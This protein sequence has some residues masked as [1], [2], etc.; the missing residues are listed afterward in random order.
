MKSQTS[1]I[2]VFLALAGLLMNS[3]AQAQ[4]REKKAKSSE[5]A[6]E[7]VTETA[8]AP[9]APKR[10]A[11]GL[12]SNAAF[13]GEGALTG[14]IELDP[15]TLIQGYLTVPSSSPFTFILGGAFKYTIHENSSAG[16]H[17]G[18]GAA[19]GTAAKSAASA[20]AA[21][22]AAALTGATTSTSSTDLFFE[23]GGIAGIHA[24]F[25]GVSNM[26]IHLDAGPALHLQ[27]NAN[28]FAVGTF[29]GLLGA[30]ILYYF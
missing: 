5:S 3:G 11:L 17:V 16:L 24:P 19:I 23:L 6:K 22:A 25:P 30:S 2:L 21:A 29:G 9:S 10:M 15:K 12:S 13:S 28:D 7:T 4:P 27:S 1:V 26:M 20:A 18:G 14:A 8:A